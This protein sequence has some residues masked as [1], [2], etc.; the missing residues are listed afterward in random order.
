M[1]SR[2]S[3]VLVRLF[4]ISAPVALFTIEQQDVHVPGRLLTVRRIFPGRLTSQGAFVVLSLL[5]Q[6]R[7]DVWRDPVE[8]GAATLV[9][10]VLALVNM[11]RQRH[12]LLH[13]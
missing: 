1:D 3:G 11:L 8:A 12:H 13:R 4:A 5:L 10:V 6:G 2:T 7:L 9:W